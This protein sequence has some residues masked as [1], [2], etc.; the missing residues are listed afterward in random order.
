MGKSKKTYRLINN[1]FPNQIINKQTQ[2]TLEKIKMENITN[3]AKKTIN[4]VS[5]F[6]KGLKNMKA[7]SFRI[8]TVLLTSIWHWCEEISVASNLCPFIWVQN[9]T[10]TEQMSS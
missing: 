10:V 1:H 4:L 5:W 3:N 7:F 8:K 2:Q 9:G 6:Y